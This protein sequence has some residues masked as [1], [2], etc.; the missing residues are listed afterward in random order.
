VPVRSLQDWVAVRDRLAAIP[1]VRS[2]RL[3]SLGR[4]EARVEIRYVGDAEQLRTALAQRDLELDGADPD[5]VLQ[6]RG[7]AAAPAPVPAAAT[8]PAPPPAAPEPAAAAPAPA[9][10]APAPAA[11]APAASPAPAPE[12]PPPATPR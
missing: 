3:L 1:A 11:P 12:A 5:W 6:R 7:A 9:A 4:D 8:P 10:P 2:S